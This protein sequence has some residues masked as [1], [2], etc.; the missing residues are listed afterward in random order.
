MNRC[1]PRPMLASTESARPG[2]AL[3]PLSLALAIMLALSVYPPLV[4][5]RSGHADHPGLMLLCWSM[6]AGFTRGVGLCPKN[7]LAGA[8]L[9]GWA[10][11]LTLGLAIARFALVF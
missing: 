4:V 1:A 7:Q 2:L 8:L 10:C 3:L 11:L 6:S 9:S 5:G